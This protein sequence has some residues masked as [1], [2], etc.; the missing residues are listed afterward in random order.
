MGTCRYCEKSAQTISDVIGFCADCIRDHIFEVGPEIARVHAGSRRA[1][2]LPVEPPRDESGRS[3]SL[4]LH[5]C[6]I[7]EGGTGFCGVRHVKDGKL[8]GGRPDEGKL[9][10]YHD[11]LPTNCVANFVCPAGT[12]C[13]YPRYAHLKGPEYGYKNLAVFYHACSFNCLYC[14]NYHF[15]E[16]TFSRGKFHAKDLASAVDDSTSCICYF[17]GDP[18]P[19]ILHALK[20]SKLA[21]RKNPDRILRICWETNGAQQEPY[22]SM[23]ADIS[24]A[25]GGCIKFDLKAWDDGLHKSLCGVSNQKTLDNFKQLSR[26]IPERPDPPFLIASTLLVPGYIDEREVDA[27][28]RY[29]SGLN[30]EIPYSLLGFYPSFYLRDLPTTSRRH[31]LRCQE[32]AKHAGIRRVHIGNVHLLGNDYN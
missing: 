20:A 6:R 29:I 25:S 21:I 4:C 23:M 10:Y 5:R 11:P 22:L 12:G 3:C 30:P 27:I 17:G 18:G 31:A 7:P 13:G 9:S 15:K 1:Y 2:G 19:Q 8:R 24:L 28:A 14:Q 26:R 16:V 32:A